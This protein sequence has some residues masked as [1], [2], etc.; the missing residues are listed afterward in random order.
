MSRTLKSLIPERGGIIS[1]PVCA[2]ILSVGFQRERARDHVV[3]AE[4]VTAPGTDNLAKPS[5]IAPHTYHVT[6]TDRRS[7]MTEKR[8]VLVDADMDPSDAAEFINTHYAERGFDVAL[9]APAVPIVAPT[10]DAKLVPVV[11]YEVPDTGELGFDEEAWPKVDV[12]FEVV[13]TGASSRN[14]MS[15]FIGTLQRPQREDPT[16]DA[17]FHIYAHASDF[18]RFR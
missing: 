18:I 14:S 2:L 4:D 8:T 7:N 1:L 10:V 11:W 3:P 17:T 9:D 16:K 6:L 5:G 13:P 12:L 15:V